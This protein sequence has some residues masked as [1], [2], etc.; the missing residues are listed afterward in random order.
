M[1]LPAVHLD[2]LGSDNQDEKI[3]VVILYESWISFLAC[4]FLKNSVYWF[5][6]LT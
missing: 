5:F 3:Y 1:K 2:S 6:E 4:F